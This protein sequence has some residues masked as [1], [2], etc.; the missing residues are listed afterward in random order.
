[1]K[2][3]KDVTEAYRIMVLMDSRI[4]E[5]EEWIKETGA[6]PNIC[7]KNILGVKCLTCYC[8]KK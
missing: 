1:M 3:P 6:E 4:K 7:I 2:R 5:L 8:E